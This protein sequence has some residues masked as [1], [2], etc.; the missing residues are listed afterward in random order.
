MR[1]QAKHPHIFTTSEANALGVSSQLL[2]HYLLK[3]LIERASHGVYRFPSASGLDLESQI[4]ELLAGVPQAIV[5]HKTAL[6]L[7]GLTEDNPPQIDLLVSD[8]N[9]PKRKLEDVRLHPSA[10]GLLRYGLTNLRG[11]PITSLERTLVD[12]LRFGE[13]LSMVIAAFRE[14]QAKNMKPSLTRIRKLGSLLHAKARVAIL[15]EALL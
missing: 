8:K 12:L 9:I 13:P 6:R 3:G 7:Y 4:K 5:S 10:A 15:L 1:I 14:A 2:R 11:I